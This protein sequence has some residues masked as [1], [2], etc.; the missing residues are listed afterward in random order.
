MKQKITKA[1]FPVAGLGTR[2]LPATKSIPKELLPLVDRPLVQY[3]VDEAREAGIEDFVFVSARG[4][5]AMADYFDRYPLL[6]QILRD[7]GKDALLE[8]LE[9]SNIS[10]GSIAYVRQGEPL[11]LGHA[12]ACA[13]K[14][15]ADDEYF[16]VVLPDDVV[17]A[18]PG[19]LAQMVKEWEKSPANIVGTMEVAADKTDQYGILD[20]DCDGQRL[21]RARGLVEK[22]AQDVAPSNMAVIGRYLLSPSIMARLCVQEPGVGGE[23]QLTDAIN[24]EAHAMGNVYGFR[25]SGQRY[26]CGSK[27]GYLQATIKY[28]LQR[29]SLRPEMLAF[30]KDAI[31]EHEGT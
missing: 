14:F 31:A 5:T 16:A 6:E 7:D 9:A 11:G 12:V 8:R 22:P 19:C 2:F 3:A 23:I 13:R 1:V 21:L 4:K 20:A 24:A 27:I 29:D 18:Q 15:V 30:M 17:Q 28:G 26:D 10:S 25:F